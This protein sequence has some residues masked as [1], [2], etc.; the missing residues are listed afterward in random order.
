MREHY[1]DAFRVCTRYD[2]VDTRR[3]LKLFELNIRAASDRDHG[4]FIQEMTNMSNLHKVSCDLL[5]TNSQLE[6]LRSIRVTYR[7]QLGLGSN[8]NVVKYDNLA[9]C[10]KLLIMNVWE[11]T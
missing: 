3:D 10:N 9:F 2:D 4:G 11:R 6:H 8:Q 7:F 1:S 5:V